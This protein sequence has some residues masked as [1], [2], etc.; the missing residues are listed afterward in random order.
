MKKSFGIGK[1]IKK[2]S[3]PDTKARYYLNNYSDITSLGKII[4]P[5]N[6]QQIF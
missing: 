6:E 4:S 3:K 5:Q 1:F 2:Q